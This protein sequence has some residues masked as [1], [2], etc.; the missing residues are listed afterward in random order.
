MKVGIYVRVST[1]EQAREGLSLREQER[2]C[3][4]QANAL[5]HTKVKVYRDA[6]FSGKDLNRP[7]LQALLLDEPDMVIVWK[8]DRISRKLLDFL[9]F[10]EQ[11]SVISVTE[12][13]DT[14]KPSGRMMMA[15]LASFA[16][17]EREII[18]ERTLMGMARAKEEGKHIG[19][20]PFGSR[21]NRAGGIETDP[22]TKPILDMILDEHRA[23]A[24]LRVIQKRVKAQ[25][26]L[27]IPQSTIHYRI[28]NNPGNVRYAPWAKAKVR[29]PTYFLTGVCRCGTCGK[30]LTVDNRDPWYYLRCRYDNLRFRYG[31]VWEYARRRFAEEV[32]DE[33]PGDPETFTE[34]YGRIGEIDAEIDRLKDAYQAGAFSLEEFFKRK[35]PLDAEREGLAKEVGKS[36][37]TPGPT[38][39]DYFDIAVKTENVLAVNEMLKTMF[40]EGLIV[41]SGSLS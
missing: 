3:R 34:E 32:K 20:V 7:G 6:G 14:S 21:R 41:Q 10:A 26:K 25:F 18:I 27:V 2:R 1:R 38:F 35:S 15:I 30:A 5:G 22:K 12:S 37:F 33:G 23:G 17:Y 29:E 24:S 11:F 4:A 9:R 40:P 13:V 19:A 8:F 36:K 16:E 31:D 28:A 39:L